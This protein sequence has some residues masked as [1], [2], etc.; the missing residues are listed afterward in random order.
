ML[1]PSIHQL[2]LW[3]I[4]LAETLPPQ[5]TRTKTALPLGIPALPCIPTWR[6]ELFPTQGD[7]GRHIK[8]QLKTVF[9]SNTSYSQRNRVKAEG[10]V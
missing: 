10:P 1:E 9:L 3:N 7:L 8:K 6:K 5:E 2:Q 4:P